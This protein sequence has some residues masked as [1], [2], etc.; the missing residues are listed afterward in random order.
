MVE[1]AVRGM[2][3]VPP[4]YKNAPGPAQSGAMASGPELCSGQDDAKL[5]G[6]PDVLR[7][8]DEALEVQPQQLSQS[9]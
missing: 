2:L 3:A 8:I 5:V 9:S 6:H 4:L 7:R 1:A